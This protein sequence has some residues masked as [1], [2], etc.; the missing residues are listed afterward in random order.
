MSWF[1]KAFNSIKSV[2]KSPI[3]K[4]AAGGLAIAFPAIGIPAGAALAIGNKALN[5][6]N[7]PNPVTRAKYTAMVNNTE[8]LA[9]KG[10]P[11]AKRAFMAM[12]LAKDAK[13]GVPAAVSEVQKIRIHGVRNRAAAVAVMKQYKMHPRTGILQC[14]PR[15]RPAQQ[16]RRA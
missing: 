16:R 7:S 6:A 10:D 5:L 4:I 14:I 3:F 15:A 13:A 9:K 1:K 2:T 12:K 11:G 8:A